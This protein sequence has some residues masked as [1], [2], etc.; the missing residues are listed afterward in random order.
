MKEKFSPASANELANTANQDGSI[1][2]FWRGFWHGLILPVTFIISLFKEDVGVYETHNNGNWYNFGFLLG[3][4]IVFGGNRS[5]GNRSGV[6]T[7]ANK[8]INPAK[9]E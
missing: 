1:A 3:L 7:A 6:S 4:M 2:G 5:G 8:Q 9:D